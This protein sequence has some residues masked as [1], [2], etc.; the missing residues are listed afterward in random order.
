VNAKPKQ[1]LTV[2]QCLLDT[3][4][5]TVTDPLSFFGPAFNDDGVAGC[6][7]Y[8]EDDHHN[9]DDMPVARL[10]DALS[11]AADTATPCAA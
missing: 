11:A 8:D 3:A 7:I 2:Q 5:T 10:D 1:P 4:T 6:H 9:D